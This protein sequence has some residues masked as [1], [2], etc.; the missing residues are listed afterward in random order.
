MKRLRLL[1]ILCAAYILQACP[2]AKQQ[3][4]SKP[5]SS[6][7]PGAS[8]DTHDLLE[9]LQGKWRS[10]QD[11]S[12]VWQLYANQYKLYRQNAAIDSAFVD[13]DPACTTAPCS[14][15]SDSLSEGWCLLRRQGEQIRCA[16]VLQCD[17]DTLKLL[18]A[19][20]GEAT[21]VYTRMK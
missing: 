15:I 6:R 10:I 21:Q 1:F 4:S 11:Q 7:E 19:G 9:L 13:I 3:L 16:K 5:E 2:G 17:R 12:L 8:A 20:A 18:W 14:A